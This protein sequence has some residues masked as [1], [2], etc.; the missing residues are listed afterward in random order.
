MYFDVVRKGDEYK[1]ANLSRARSNYYYHESRKS[2]GFAVPMSAGSGGG[3]SLWFEDR[4]PKSV[5]IAVVE[6]KPAVWKG[7]AC[8]EVRTKW[9]NR[10]GMI[11]L[12]STF[13]D[14][15]NDY[16]TIATETDWKLDFILKKEY[17]RFSEIEYAPSAE[18][19]LLPKFVRRTQQYQ[20]E[21]L[22]K[23]GDIEFVSY[24]KY[25][26]SPNEFHV[27]QL[28]GLATPEVGPATVNTT[29]PPEPT[30]PQKQSPVWPWV[31]IAIGFILVVA[32]DFVSRRYRRTEAR[33]VPED[34]P[35]RDTV[36]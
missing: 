2:I 9:D 27:E 5:L 1:I 20:G 3:T 34:D 16:I 13:L 18:G 31:A 7:R 22:R 14:P 24:E 30:A 23:S 10:H 15:A 8:V 35:I 26:P 32:A 28:Y 19:F 11:D 29:L 17:R 33:S 4:E 21:P 36:P 6:V 25:M 12:S